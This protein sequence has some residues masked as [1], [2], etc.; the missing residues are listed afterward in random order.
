MANLLLVLHLSARIG[1]GFGMRVLAYDIKKTKKENYVKMVNLE[2]LIKRSDIITI[3]IHL[4]KYTENLINYEF[5]KKM[6]NNAFLINTSRGKIINEEDLLIALKKNLIRGAGLD[7]IDGEWLD[8]ETRKKHKLIA[9]A[10]KHSNLL[11]TPHI[12]GATEESI[13]YSR[14]FMAKKIAKKIKESV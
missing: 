4:N 3:H 8:D 13:Y 10:R 1:N 11:I 2:S 9:Y 14:V 5:L 7:V 12:G 6:K